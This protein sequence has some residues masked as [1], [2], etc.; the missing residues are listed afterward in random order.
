M[1]KR[2]LPL[3]FL[4]AAAVC[5]FFAPSAS[6]AGAAD[7]DHTIRPGI[8]LGTMT[9][10]MTKAQVRKISGNMD[11]KYTLSDGINVEY[12]EWRER[13]PK[14][15]PNLRYFYDKTGKLIQINCTAPV[16]ATAGGISCKS[17]MAAIAAAYKNLKKIP[18]QSLNGF[19]DYYDEQKQG[20]A[21]KFVSRNPPANILYAVIVHRPGQP[22]R[23]DRYEQLQH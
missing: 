19:V 21:F 12:A 22:V 23:I 1:V 14:Q 18:C 10:G 2:A 15:N 7:E 16:P 11:G 3:F 6:A 9:L 13:P 17:S 20:I 8:G 4:Q 5:V